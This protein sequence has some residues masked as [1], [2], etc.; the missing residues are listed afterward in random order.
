MIYKKSNDI[1]NFKKENLKIYLNN[2]LKMGRIVQG[3]FYKFKD[4]Y[5]EKNK[6]LCNEIIKQ[7]DR[8]DFL[9]TKLEYEGLSMLGSQNF[10]GIYLKATLL[11]IKMSYIFENMGD[12]C[13]ENAKL[14]LEILK[15]PQLV[16][17]LS[18]EDIFSQSQKIL[19]LSLKLLS[20]FV[21]L[22]IQKLT[23]QDSQKNFFLPAK[24]IC[25]LDQDINSLLTAF[26]K[27]LY[28][29]KESTKTINLHL[30]VL[31]NIE[32]FSDFSTN[33]SENVLWALSAIKYKCRG[34]NLEYFYSYEEEL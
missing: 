29:S 5:F 32:Q 2:V 24:E 9:E 13:E 12:L 14:N 26:K 27:N 30:N 16:N 18:F 22:D 4:A 1:S 6:N 15:L 3:M 10:T 7:D 17:M 34:T 33:I 19:T 8:L 11:G 21:N 23:E 31:S 28:R 25:F 20:N